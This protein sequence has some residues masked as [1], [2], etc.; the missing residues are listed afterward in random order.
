MDLQDYR[1]IVNSKTDLIN[2]KAYLDSIGEKSNFN[3]FISPY[4]GALCVLHGNVWIDFHPELAFKP[5]NCH[6]VTLE[7]FAAIC[8]DHYLE[9]L[10]KRSAV[11]IT[12]VDE[13]LIVRHHNKCR[14]KDVP[15]DGS[16][17]RL[18]TTC[19]KN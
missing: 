17:Q 11:V 5:A 18:L 3:T 8:E 7:E 9:S 14:K 1:I 12:N 19:N 4:K 6:D 2:T 15:I 10:P 16:M 13:Y